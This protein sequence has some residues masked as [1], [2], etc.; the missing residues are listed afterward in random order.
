MAAFSR[1]Y[2]IM[3]ISNRVKDHISHPHTPIIDINR[4]IT[5]LH[6]FSTPQHNR[7]RISGNI[8]HTRLLSVEGVRVHPTQFALCL[9]NVASM[10][11]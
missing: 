10:S 4:T 8:L 3:L 7:C 11:A 9:D 1:H 5:K 2:Y 6:R